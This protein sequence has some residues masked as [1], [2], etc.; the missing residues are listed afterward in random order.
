MVLTHTSLSQKSQSN[1][2]RSKGGGYF[3]VSQI[4]EFNAGR[5]SIRDAG[6]FRKTETYSS[7]VTV[8]LKGF[9]CRF[10]A[11][12][13]ADLREHYLNSQFLSGWW[14]K[15]F[16]IFHNIWDNPSHWLLFFKMVKTTNQ[17]CGMLR[18]CWD[19]L[20]P[21]PSTM[22]WNYSLDLFRWQ[23]HCAQTHE[24]HEAY[25]ISYINPC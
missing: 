7:W 9:R 14:F 8:Q 16:F 4:L 3:V 20:N 21:N 10:V 13:F 11:L 6:P 2:Q 17:L 19:E 12:G 18:I 22:F 23:H 25:H 1:I 15:H 24:A 5:T